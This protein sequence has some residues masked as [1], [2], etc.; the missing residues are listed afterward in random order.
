VKQYCIWI[1]S[2]ENVTHSKCYDEIGISLAHAF[3]VLGIDAPI[4]RNVQEIRG[5]PVILGGIF[6]P[7][8]GPV[9]LPANSIVFNLE[10]IADN[11]AGMDPA[12]IQLLRSFEVW[13]YNERNIEALAGLGIHRTKLCGIGYAEALSSIPTSQH[14]DIDVLFY[15]S[16]NDR[17][18]S[19][20]Q[21]LEKQNCKVGHMFGVYGKQRDDYIAR[22][23]IVLNLHFY[24]AKVFE[25]VR[26]SYLLANRVFVVSEDSPAESC[27][28]QL[29]E[30]M[31]VCSY[32][33]I[34]ETCLYYLRHEGKRQAIAETGFNLFSQMRQEDYLRKCLN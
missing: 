33:D 5:C 7:Q 4:V 17:R 6:L 11:S 2:P 29:R 24:P 21:Q 8:L 23:K 1:V 19:I 32:D 25:I 34:V 12:H 22:S 9:S 20:L 26:V 13:D 3:K 27:L 31:A 14:K 10:Q 18:S 28:T 16:L 15:G 30:G